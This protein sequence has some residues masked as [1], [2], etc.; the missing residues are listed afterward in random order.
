MKK[1]LTLIIA[2]L[3]V[4]SPALTYA[5]VCCC[6]KEQENKSQ[7]SE[8]PCHEDMKMAKK[9]KDP[10]KDPGFCADCDCEKINLSKIVSNVM[11]VKL[12]DELLD[13]HDFSI[14][15][16]YI[17]RHLDQEEAPPKKSSI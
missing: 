16:P 6:M 12:P 1:I 11:M 13:M 7:K 15:D 17:S 8:M 2:T 4:T 3:I 14:H 9:D 5:S 10:K